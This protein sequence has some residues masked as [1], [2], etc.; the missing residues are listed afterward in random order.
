MY[1]G[2]KAA[3]ALWRATDGAPRAAMAP[4]GTDWGGLP[5]EVSAAQMHEAFLEAWTL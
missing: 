3:F 4:F 1:A 5:Y 2:A